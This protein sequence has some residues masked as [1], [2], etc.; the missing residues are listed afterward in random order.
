MVCNG[1]YSDPFIPNL[2]GREKFKGKQWHSH[3]YR[4]PSSFARK[5]VLLVGAGPSG[6]DIGAQIVTVANQVKTEKKISKKTKL[7][8]QILKFDVF[9]RLKDLLQVYMSHNNNLKIPLAQG[10]IEKPYLIELT[11]YSAIFQDGTE[12]KIDEVL[13]CTGAVAGRC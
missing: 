6:V 11:E 10:I 3:D 8:Y 5:K 2:R 12:V 13:F 9:P 1:H 7:L 4:E